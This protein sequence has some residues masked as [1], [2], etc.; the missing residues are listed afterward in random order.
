M[1][2]K[3]AWTQTCAVD[4]PLSGLKSSQIGP[5]VAQ[6][7]PTGW[8]ISAFPDKTKPTT[9]NGGTQVDDELKTMTL[10]HFQKRKFWTCD[11]EVLLF[12]LSNAKVMNGNRDI[13]HETTVTHV[14]DLI[15]LLS[16]DPSV[17]SETQKHSDHSGSNIASASSDTVC[18]VCNKEFSS[19]KARL[20][21][22][23]CHSDARPFGCE[24]CGKTFKLQESVKEHHRNVHPLKYLTSHG[25]DVKMLKDVLVDAKAQNPLKCHLCGFQVK[26]K[27]QY[28]MHMSSHG[29]SKHDIDARGP[30]VKQEVFFKKCP[31]CSKSCRSAGLMKL[32]MREAHSNPLA[33][34]ECSFCGQRYQKKT[35]LDHHIAYRHKEKT[36]ACPKCDK[37][38]AT[39]YDLKRHS[40]V[41]DESL[42]PKCSSCDRVFTT[43]VNLKKHVAKYH[44]EDPSDSQPDR[45]LVLVRKS[46]APIAGQGAVKR[47]PKP[48]P[49][50]KT[51]ELRPSTCPDSGA[52]LVPTSRTIP[53]VGTTVEVSLERR[54]STSCF[55]TPS[56]YNVISTTC[57]QALF[58]NPNEDAT[59]TTLTMETS[60]RPV[61]MTTLELF[62]QENTVALALQPPSGIYPSASSDPLAATK[63]IV[64]LSSLIPFHQ[65][66]VP[67]VTNHVSTQL[68]LTPTTDNSAMVYAPNTGMENLAL[69]TQGLNL[70]NNGLEAATQN[71]SYS[72]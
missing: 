29:D 14:E 20:R 50:T 25:R 37:K 4:V 30:P 22:Q 57:D 3:E 40:V 56:S 1:T 62:T 7:L 2:V 46:R 24:Y 38:Y 45:P 13:Q 58:L 10:M 71:K 31:I 15:K 52:E 28:E 55:A 48:P 59:T 41:H 39:T 34:F 61:A 9:D 63:R 65:R 42:K 51:A 67:A 33:R 26:D 27:E 54:G 44:S 17:E 60:L 35:L 5:W 19:K 32:H 69:G 16:F 53:D 12:G 70:S 64:Q 72:T 68:Q 11:R 36:I 8:T 66:D 6:W 43:K 23:V 49:K 18:V 47:R 21:H